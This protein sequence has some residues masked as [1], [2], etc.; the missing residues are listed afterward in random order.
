MTP[1]IPLRLLAPWP[2]LAGLACAGPMLMVPGGELGGQVVTERV[3][4]F[5]FTRDG[6]FELEVRPSDPYS[7]QLNYVVRDG[8][9]HVDPG[10]G[11]RWLD[12]MREDPNVRVRIDGKIYPLRAELVGP[13]GSVEGFPHDR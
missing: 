12:Y 7:V 3:D 6:V 10:E 1:R 8:V 4:D 13:P 2:L 5:S 9:L 11:R